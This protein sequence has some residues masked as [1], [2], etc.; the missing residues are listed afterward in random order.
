MSDCIFCGIAA[1]DVEAE[2][3]LETE[4]AVAFLD[5]HPAA[6]GH[7]V[8]IP[9][10]HAASLPELPDEAVGGL[11]RTVKAAMRKVSDALQ[12]VGMHVGWN[13]GR[14][15]G[16][17]VFHLH[18][19]LLPRQQPGRGVQ[20]LGEGGEPGSLAEVAAAIRSA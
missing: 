19:H 14:G 20:L 4:D 15:A 16:Q 2:V 11:F 9:R 12:P 18:V 17:H 10:V 8:V 13:H 3:V 6:R 5:R 7:V 1:G